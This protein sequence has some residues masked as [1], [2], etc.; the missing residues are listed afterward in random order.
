MALSL[1]TSARRACR[2]AHGRVVAKGG[3]LQAMKLD[4]VIVQLPRF[5]LAL[6]GK[7]PAGP[8]GP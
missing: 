3:E 2:K 7:L 8:P 5:R 6:K 4:E 1:P